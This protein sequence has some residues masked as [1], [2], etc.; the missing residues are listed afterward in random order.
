ML[1][2]QDKLPRL[3]LFNILAA[4]QQTCTRGLWRM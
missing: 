1:Q 2:K 3:A 4:I